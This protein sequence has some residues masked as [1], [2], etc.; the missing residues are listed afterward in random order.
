MVS[1]LISGPV[2]GI[3]VGE[4]LPPSTSWRRRA[5]FAAATE[6]D[7]NAYSRIC[8]TTAQGR[9]CHLKLRGRHGV[10]HVQV[11]APYT[12]ATGPKRLIWLHEYNR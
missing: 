8:V 3:A 11:H 5:K 9:E 6:L 2:S 12:S 4:A 7:R 1:R 10:S